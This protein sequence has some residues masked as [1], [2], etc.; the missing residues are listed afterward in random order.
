MKRCPGIVITTGAMIRDGKSEQKRGFQQTK[1]ADRY[2]G[3]QQQKRVTGFCRVPGDGASPPE[4][5]SKSRE[6]S[7]DVALK[8]IDL[9]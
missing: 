6:V 2:D 3:V 8:K 1:A 7:S 5:K 9:K 4:E